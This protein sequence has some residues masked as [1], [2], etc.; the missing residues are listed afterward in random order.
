MESA[1]GGAGGWFDADEG[2]LGG[3]ETPWQM[4][5]FGDA[6]AQVA[7]AA[8]GRIGRSA[9]SHGWLCAQVGAVVLAADAQS[10][11]QFARA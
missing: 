1:C 11:G 7:E 4:R 8:D 3:Q 9:E 10:N 2:I 6:D 5:G